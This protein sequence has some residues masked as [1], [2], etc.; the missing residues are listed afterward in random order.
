MFGDHVSENMVHEGLKSAGGIAESEEHDSWFKKSKRSD[1]CSF[2]LIFLMNMDV[3]VTPA[4]V[5]FSEVESFMS[6]TSSE[7]RGSG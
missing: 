3:V 5:E 4:N 1:E 2:P 6:S 7:I